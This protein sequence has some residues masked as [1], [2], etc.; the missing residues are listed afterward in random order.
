[1]KRNDSFETS[2]LLDLFL[3]KLHHQ[4]VNATNLLANKYG[5]GTDIF[6]YVYIC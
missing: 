6:E 2:C 5:H 3:S 4:L 1:M